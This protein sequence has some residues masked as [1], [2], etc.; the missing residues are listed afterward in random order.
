VIGIAFYALFLSSGMVES[1][2]RDP[3]LTG[4]TVIW[5]VVLSVR[6][7][8]LVGTGFESFWMGRRLHRVW[9]LTMTG[10][11]EAHNGYLELYLN[12]GWIG[13]ILLAG[14][15]IN[16]YRNV[17]AAFRRDPALANLNLAFFVVAIIYN[18]T[19]AGFRETTLVWIFFLLATFAVPRMA[20]PRVQLR[21]EVAP[22]SELSDYALQADPV[23]AVEFAASEFSSNPGL[24]NPGLANYEDFSESHI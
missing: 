22:S 20:S 17:I 24:A 4:R 21:P 12:L 7:N 16:G 3:T 15:I 19:E 13:V 14:L 9:E 1:L 6:G 2:G 5:D 8:A 23:V 11:Q 18:F 10:L